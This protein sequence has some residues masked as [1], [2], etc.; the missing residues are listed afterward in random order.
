VREGLKFIIHNKWKT[1]DITYNK[2]SILISRGW[3]TFVLR[4][5]V[6]DDPMFTNILFYAYLPIGILGLIGLAK[7]CDR[8]N[9]PVA[10]MMASYLVLSVSLA[11][12]K[13]RY[14]LLIEPMMILYA[15]FLIGHVWRAV[16]SGITRSEP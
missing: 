8:R 11:I 7:L 16:A 15:S 13:Y 9:G 6:G 12:F 1:V 10:I 3:D 5:V 14:R 2:L 4:K